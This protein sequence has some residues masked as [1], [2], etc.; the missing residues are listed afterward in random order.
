MKWTPRAWPPLVR[1]SA[2][3]LAL[4][5]ALVAL[6]PLWCHDPDT[7]ADP[8]GTA[9]LPPGSHRFLL[10]L[11]DGST[12][13]ASTA[14]RTSGGWEVRRLGELRRLPE[15]QVRQR[16][17]RRFWLGT[18][19]LGRDVLARVLWGG[20]TS[21]ALGLFALAISTLLGLLVGLV[22]G[23]VGGFV[24]AALM[25]AADAVLAVPMLVLVLLLAALLRPSTAVLA[26]VI[27]LSSW[28][29]VARLVRT[30]VAALRQREFVLGLRAIGASQARILLRHVLPNALA[31][32]GQDAA[33]RLG[34]LMLLESSLSFL[35][36]G[37]Q[38]PTASWGSLLADGQAA[39]GSAWWLVVFPGC[40]LAAS[41]LAAALLAEGL[42][43]KLHH[44]R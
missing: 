23:W 44:F 28:M 18:D 27:G 10:T 34:D 8:A 30:Q 2:A 21:L 26:V 38:P 1:A 9:L 7:I 17:A 5:G 43:E 40:L 39:L 20:R 22:A 31:P 11:A 33:L 3:A 35:G 15:D 4:V 29:G 24:D 41:V 14:T 6:G 42:Q 25:R 16:E 19:A 32:L 13:A 36:F 37:V 12:L